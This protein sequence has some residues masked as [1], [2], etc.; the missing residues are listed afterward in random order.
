[1]QKLEPKNSR[2]TQL[3]EAASTSTALTHVLKEHLFSL[4][5]LQGIVENTQVCIGRL[6]IDRAESGAKGEVATCV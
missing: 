3:E 2:K 4:N 6:T 1:M 5:D